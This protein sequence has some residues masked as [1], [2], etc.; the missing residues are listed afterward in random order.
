MIINHRSEYGMTFF[1]LRKQTV[2][3]EFSRKYKRVKTPP[4]YEVRGGAIIDGK[5]ASPPR[6][7]FFNDIKNIFI[8]KDEIWVF[9]STVDKENR[10]LVDV[11]DLEGIYV[12][13]FYLDIPENLSPL[14]YRFE[15]VTF[16]GDFFY[17]IETEDD[18]TYVL[19]KYRLLNL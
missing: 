17:F 15:P 11:F 18:D 16:D 7:K 14:R 10:T 9:T 5:P 12:D 13:N 8:H 19:K 6:P 1:D 4:D 2:S 3:F